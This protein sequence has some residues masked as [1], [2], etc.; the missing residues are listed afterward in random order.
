MEIRPIFRAMMRSPTGAVLIALQV[1]FTMAVVINSVFIVQERIQKISRPTGMDVDNIITVASRRIGED[2]VTLD[3]AYQ[4]LE[5]LAAIPGV[6]AVTTTNHIPLSG[7]GWSTQLKA[8]TE[9]SAAE[10]ATARYN[11][12]E[13]A[14]DTLGVTLEAGRSFRQEEIKFI[15]EFSTPWDHVI[16]TRALADALLPDGRQALG[17]TVYDGLDRPVTIIGIIEHMQGAWVSWD[18]LDHVMLLAEVWKGLFTRYLIRTEPGERDRVMALIEEKL[19]AVEDQRVI[20]DLEAHTDIVHR[21]YTRDRAMAIVLTVIIGLLVSVTALGIV[22]LA[23]FVVRHRTKQIG[24]RRAIGARKIDII[25]Y[26]LV[27]N[28]LMT[29]MGVVL[30]TVLTVALNYV[31]VTQYSLTRLD[32]A[33]I[34]IGILTLWGLP[35]CL[36]SGKSTA[37]ERAPE[38]R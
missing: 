24:T 29:T 2:E 8:S 34:P 16:I 4:D 36:R 28:W 31:L 27:E 18:E 26:F 10:I 35:P 5:A 13:G 33:Y 23:S 15:E 14:I 30:G 25:R 19:F 1:A 7:S 38:D 22:G 3:K 21:S 32:P 6:V 17:A 11:V 20:Q 12:T 37:S 9:D